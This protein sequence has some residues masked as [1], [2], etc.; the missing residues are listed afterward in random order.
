MGTSLGGL[1]AIR[2]V[3]SSLP[4]DFHVPIA[5]VQHRG[6]YQ[7]ESLRGVLQ[8]ATG[9]EVVEVDDKLP[10]E[11]GRLYFAPQDYHLLVDAGSFALSVDDKVQRA[12]PSIDVLFES[13]AFS[14]GERLAAVVLTGASRD[15]AQG[16]RA[17]LAHGGRVLAEDPALAESP[18]MPQAAVEAGAEALSLDG[19][20]ARLSAFASEPR[21]AK[22][23]S[24]SW[25]QGQRR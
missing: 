7:D 22:S 6:V 10:I 21:R 23:G 11:N 13:A 24:E 8:A 20:G 15:G 2:R 4:R 19:I 3:L 17:V 18:L 1:D 16:T 9:L 14:Y 25:P 5:L 12:R